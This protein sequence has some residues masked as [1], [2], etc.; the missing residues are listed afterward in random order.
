MLVGRAILKP[1]QRSVR[2]GVGPGPR[3]LGNMPHEKQSKHPAATGEAEH[4]PAGRWCPFGMRTP[5]RRAL[6]SLP[7]ESAALRV[8]EPIRSLA[9]FEHRANIF[10]LHG[11]FYSILSANDTA[12]RLH[13]TAPINCGTIEWLKYLLMPSRCAMRISHDTIPRCVF[14]RFGFLC[15]LTATQ[16]LLRPCRAVHK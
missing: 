8:L 5:A 1:A 12:V 16:T 4:A 13:L 14:P 3:L 15:C 6:L 7:F 9:L 2:I 11:P 10:R